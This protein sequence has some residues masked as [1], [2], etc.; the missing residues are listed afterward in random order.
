MPIYKQNNKLKYVN[1]NSG[2]NIASCFDLENIPVS[3]V[4]GVQHFDA[5]PFCVERPAFIKY[6]GNIP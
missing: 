6:T 1:Y 2:P 5:L 3:P 4:I